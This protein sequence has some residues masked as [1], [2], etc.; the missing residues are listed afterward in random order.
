MKDKGCLLYFLVVLLIIGGVFLFHNRGDGPI[1]V[2]LLGEW[3]GGRDR[4]LGLFD[5]EVS[6]EQLV[7]LEIAGNLFVRQFNDA[8]VR[9]RNGWFTRGG[10]RRTAVIRIPPGTHTLNCRFL[11]E[12][13][14]AR[15]LTPGDLVIT[16][17][18]T[19]GNTYRLTASIAG[20]TGRRGPETEV[21][22]WNWWRHQRLLIQTI[23]L[24][25]IEKGPTG[26]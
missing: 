20:R 11:L 17:N 24:R 5:P 12:R 13:A 3:L 14:G 23:G 15:W 18:F 22:N 9:G 10:S 26:Y 4:D 19:A 25:I 21:D 16:H 2:Y 8:T 6:Q 1:R 7:T